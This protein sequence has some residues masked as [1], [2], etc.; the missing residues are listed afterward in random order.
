[1]VPHTELQ[2]VALAAACR[3]STNNHFDPCCP[4][5]LGSVIRAVIRDHEDA[6]TRSEL[7][8][9]VPD[10]WKY[11]RTLIMRGNE[12]GRPMGRP[13]GLSNRSGP[14]VAQ[15]KAACQ[16]FGKPDECQ[17]GRQA[18]DRNHYATQHGSHPI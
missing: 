2:C 18:N 13:T 3:I 6:V 10:G 9:H 16:N 15:G 1:E 7:G 5:N 11:S 4:D 8:L 12:Y 17:K 14:L